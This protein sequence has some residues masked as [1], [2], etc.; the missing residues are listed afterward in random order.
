MNGYHTNVAEGMYVKRN[1]SL[2]KPRLEQLP[3]TLC[4]VFSQALVLHPSADAGGSSSV[5]G[6][7]A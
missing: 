2:K 6:T 1:S 7:F 5:S 3:E 4:F